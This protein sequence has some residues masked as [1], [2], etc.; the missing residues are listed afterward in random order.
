MS[1]RILISV[2]T[3]SRSESPR[4]TNG[5]SFFM[6]H[7]HNF[8]IAGVFDGATALKETAYAQ[9]LT[10]SAPH[11]A[12]DIAAESAATALKTNPAALADALITA[13]TTLREAGCRFNFDYTD[14]LTLPKTTATIVSVDKQK[15]I[16]CFAHIGD[17]ILLISD[18]NGIRKLTTKQ[19]KSAENRFLQ[20]LRETSIKTKLAPH[21]LN[22]LPEIQES[23]FAT[24]SRANEPNN[25]E[26]YGV[27]NGQDDERVSRFIETGIFTI[28]SNTDFFLLSDGAVP[29]HLN[30]LET[31]K[32][33][34]EWHALLQKKRA[35]GLYRFIRHQEHTDPNHSHFPR[36]KTSDDY[37][38]ISIK[39]RISH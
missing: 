30:D 33:Q 36:Y 34:K 12:S 18:R 8:L 22:N 7:Y 26:S 19:N 28:E 11:W 10:S 5:D 39:A 6:R 2:Q 32:E 17:T 25:P 14:S 23:I 4:R 21:A 20:K 24:Q 15:G 9:K 31:D 16:L 29:H 38:I 27:L 35:F 37:T 13:N 1:K 3:T